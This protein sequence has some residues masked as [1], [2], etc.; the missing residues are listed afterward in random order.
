MSADGQERHSKAVENTDRNSFSTLASTLDI[1]LSTS[2]VQRQ[3]SWM[4]FG[5]DGLPDGF[6]C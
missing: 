5:G 2:A 3:R 6:A 4:N 1:A